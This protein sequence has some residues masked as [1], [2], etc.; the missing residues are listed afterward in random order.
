[1]G[2]GVL[3]LLIALATFYDTRIN[4]R[5]ATTK[6]LQE[7]RFKIDILWKTVAISIL[8]T[9][10]A[11]THA[12]LDALTDKFVAF[13]RGEGDFSLED[14]RLLEQELEQR[15]TEINDHRRIAAALTLGLVRLFLVEKQLPQT[16][17][18]APWWKWW[19]RRNETNNPLDGGT[20]PD[21]P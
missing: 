10:H 17:P 21:S 13:H 19:K 18:A 20:H 8:P 15:L 7:I 6:E 11:P 4:T 9:V 2:V 3:G 12:H 14:A 16:K 1:M 5:L